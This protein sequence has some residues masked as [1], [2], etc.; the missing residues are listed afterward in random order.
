MKRTAAFMLLLVALSVAWSMPAN[1]Q[2]ISTQENAR[3][4]QKAAKKQQ[5]M[6]NKANKKQRKAM[7]KYSKAQRKATKK[8]NRRRVG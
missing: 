7:K 8:A 3:Q 1:A 6:L 4:S 2:R 5:K